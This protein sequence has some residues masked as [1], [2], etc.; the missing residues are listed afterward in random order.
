MMSMPYFEFVDAEGF[1]NFSLAVQSLVGMLKS[2][3]GENRCEVKYDPHIDKLLIKLSPNYRDSVVE[4]CLTKGVLS[5]NINTTYTLSDLPD[6]LQRKVRVKRIAGQAANGITKV[7]EHFKATTKRSNQTFSATKS[8]INSRQFCSYCLNKDLY[9]N[10]CTEFKNLNVTEGREWLSEEGRCD[11]CGRKHN[12]ENCTLK[13]PCH[14][15]KEIHL[16]VLREALKQSTVKINMTAGSSDRAVMIDQPKR[17]HNAHFKIVK[18]DLH[19]PRGTQETY[20]LLDDGFK[21]TVILSS[22]ANKLGLI[23]ETKTILLQTLRQY[24]VRC[25]GQCVSFTISPGL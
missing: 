17:P 5:Y 15:C 8:K 18:V 2:L 21:R 7:T 20:A 25:K 4:H 3:S 24:I 12:S 10:S 9:L 14:F 13:K 19:G 6:W 11:K 1:D 22:I 16:A 23:G